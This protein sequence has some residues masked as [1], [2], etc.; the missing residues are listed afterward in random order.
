MTFLNDALKAVGLTAA[1]AV[2]ALLGYYQVDLV[3]KDPI[4]AATFVFNTVVVIGTA[5]YSYKSFVRD[6]KALK[7]NVATLLPL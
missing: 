3:R 5:V 1:C 2:T 7:R 4:Y 6:I